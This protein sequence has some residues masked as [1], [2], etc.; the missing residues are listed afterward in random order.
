MFVF[1]LPVS[2][3]HTLVSALADAIEPAAGGLATALAIVL[4]TASVRLLLV[5]LA[6]K[7]A[8]GERA[9][10]RLMPKL[11]ALQKKHA[12]DPERFRRE[13]AALYAA[14][15]AT[16]LAGCLPMFAQAPFFMVM[17]QLFVS[18]TVAGHQ[19]LLLAHTF[20][21]APLGQN[22]VGLVGAGGALSAAGLVFA[23]LFVAL[24]LVAWWTSRR[25]A[26]TAP[27]GPM[28]TLARV[29]PFGTV[30]V[31]AFV[32]LA[33]GLYLLTSTAWTAAERA[34]LHRRIVAPTA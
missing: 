26:R 21:A 31:A 22:W 2:A 30:V 34:V 16:P 6:V 8:Q 24:A 27:E 10:A 12:R 3:A 14:E 20:L 29:L 25:A 13:T 5:P 15:G 23:G 17:Y 1:D 4:F 7:A 32:P 9:R 19:N 28:G 33:A 11:Q 18:A